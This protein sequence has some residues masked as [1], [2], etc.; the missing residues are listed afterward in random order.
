MPL[1]TSQ[2]EVIEIPDS[3]TAQSEAIVI[4]DDEV[5][6]LLDYRG[7]LSMCPMYSFQTIN[8]VLRNVL[9]TF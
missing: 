8:L 4:S 5:T 3:P 2:P 6:E 7:R 9:T 1:S